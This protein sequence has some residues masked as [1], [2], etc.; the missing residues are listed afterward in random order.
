MMVDRRHAEDP[1]PAGLLKVCDLDDHREDLD[2]V[3]Q[4]YD[5]DVKRHP[6]HQRGTRDQ[7]A[8]RQRPGVAH[9]D[10]R[11]MAVKDQETD[12]CAHARE[13]DEL[14]AA[15]DADRGDREEQ[16]GKDRDR[17]AETV[18][19]VRE[20]HGI[21]RA[22]DRAERDEDK[23]RR[24]NVHFAAQERDAERTAEPEGVQDN[25]ERH[26]HRDLQEQ[27]LLRVQALG[28]LLHDLQEVVNEAD[29][30][31]QQGQQQHRHHADVPRDHEKDD[32]AH[33]DREQEADAA[34]RGGPGLLQV[35]LG[36][37]LADLLPEFELAQ[38]RNERRRG[39]GADRERKHDI[40]DIFSDQ[41]V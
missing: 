9:K 1:L 40:E 8:E 12:Q 39:D 28:L 24:G 13:A 31:E 23:D 35:R 20:V 41:S 10:L 27:L 11:R 21:V 17:A 4:A 15:V 18:E 6:Q 19:A 26:S 36:A 25:D 14:H 37:F 3:D 38:E 2:Q 22:E 29:Q 33:E 7:T 5:Q 32:P 34:H 30:A 16:R